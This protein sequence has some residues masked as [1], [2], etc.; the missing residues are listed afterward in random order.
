MGGKKGAYVFL[1]D[2][3]FAWIPAKLQGMSGTTADVQ[4]P[5]YKDEQ[6]TICDGGKTAS[7]WIEAEV[8]LS[9]YN[10][11][12]LPMQNVDEHGKMRCFPDMVELPFLHEAAILYNLKQRHLDCHPYT[13]TGDIIIAVNPFQWFTDIYTE[14]V[15]AEY[16]NK[17]V[18]EEHEDVQ[19]ARKLVQPHVYEVSSLSYK[20]LAFGG[21]DQSILVSGESGAGKTETVKIAMNHIASVQRGRVSASSSESFSDPVVDRVLESNPLLEAFGNAMTRRNDNSSRFGKYTQL[22][23]DMGDKSMRQF[24]DKASMKC[25]LAG[26]K[27][28]VYLLEKNRVTVHDPME[29]TYHVFY[30]IIAAPDAE[31]AAFWPHMKGTTNES[32]AYV[33]TAPTNVIEKQTDAQ[34]FQN[35]VKTLKGINVDG[36]KLN[37][38]FRAICVVLQLGNLSFMKDPTDDDKSVVKDKKEFALLGDIM[39]VTENDLVACLT[40]RTMKTRTETYK[41]PLNADTSQET[42]DAFAKEIYARTFLWLVRAI[43]DATAAEYNYSGGGES[44]F[45]I[46]G[47]LDIFGFESFVRNRFEQLCINY[48]NEK[49]QAKFTEDIFRSVQEEYEFEGIP[50]DE[51]KYDDNTDVLD[52]IEGKAGLLAMLNEECVRPKGTDEAF[53]QKALAANKKSPCLI[54]SKINRKEFGIHHY[55]GKVMYDSEGFVFSNQDTLQT[56]LADCA[57]KSSNEIIAKHLSNDACSNLPEKEVSVAKKSAPKRAKSNLVAPTVWSKYKGQ[58][59]KLMGMLKVTNSRYIRCVKPNQAKK[60]YLMEHLST[61]EQLRCAGVVA[62]VTLSRSA[63]PNRLEN[64]T[65]RFKFSGMW[66]RSKFPSKGANKDAEEKLSC[67]CDALLTCALKSLEMQDNGKT[68]KMFV[69]GKTRSYFRMGALEFLEANR[70]QEMGSTAISIQRYIRG[71]F[72]RKDTKQ[73]DGKRRKAVAKIQKWYAE[74]LAA[75]EGSEKA[76]KIALAKKKKEEQERKAREKAEAKAAAAREARLAKEKADREAREAAEKAAEE[77]KER[78]EREAEA[79][80]R[81]KETEAVEKFEKDKT[82]RIKKY[83]KEVKG[84][85]KELDDKDKRWEMEINDLEQECEKIEAERDEILEQIARE[86][87]K[88]AA[89]PQLSDKEKKKLEDSAEIIAY[90]RKENKKLRGST[91]QLRKDFDTMQENNKRLLEAN[92]YAGASF[93]ALNEQSK[94]NNSNNSKLMQNLDKYKKQNGKLKEDLRMRQGYYDAEA[95]IRVNYQKSMA[96]IMEMIQDQCEDAQLTEDI[97]VLALECES[98]AKSELAAAEAA[99]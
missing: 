69:V 72:V 35:T 98:E 66:D 23:F 54:T 48:C 45:G 11:G 10:K 59:V 58:L 81:K 7:S 1:K 63:F 6:S 77:E 82:Q 68:V 21:D 62:A 4:I 18:W 89:I 31:K 25:K 47:L 42:A 67:D 19:D 61:I 49:L 91:T 83:K 56:D 75:V 20:G 97:L 41:V 85:E 60:P 74:C 53:V 9:D 32:F 51:I 15:R 39:G 12:V 50:L 14:K 22:Q 73:A 70:K 94:K 57:L 95:Q 38:L 64:K 36:E 24:G 34:H 46:I 3:E 93:E 30:Q 52:L 17:L 44:G 13:R 71:W 84:L 92:A 28:D 27:C 55:A 80:R 43:N 76:K 65:V 2:P 37:T 87:A 78:K 86:E 16:S 26:S 96:E 40:E 5:Q 8:D 33:G 79:K 99:K 90:L 29:R 88:L